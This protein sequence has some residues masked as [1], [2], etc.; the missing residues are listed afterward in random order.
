M[1]QKTSTTTCKSRL[2][3]R[4]FERQ[5]ELVKTKA[6]AIHLK[7]SDSESE[8][9]ISKKAFHQTS[10]LMQIAIQ[11]NKQQ[12]RNPV[13]CL[14]QYSHLTAN[15][16]KQTRQ[17]CGHQFLK[18][19]KACFMI[20]LPIRQ[21]LLQ[22]L[23]ERAILENDD[24]VSAMVPDKE[25]RG[26]IASGGC[27]RALVKDGIITRETMTGT[28]NIDDA[29]FFKSSKFF[30]WPCMA[31]INE[32][33]LYNQSNNVDVCTQ[34]PGQTITM[35]MGH[36]RVYPKPGMFP[37]F[38][39]RSMEQHDADLQVLL[40]TKKPYHGICGTNSLMQF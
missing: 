7:K 37:T 16:E 14:I 31:V 29:E 10:K 34:Y 32:I 12:L 5:G 27:C 4:K 8:D 25:M 26:D 38:P 18:E 9:N 15:I 6:L 19:D 40:E 33:L 30:F 24:I 11:D 13:L 23:Q 3:M 17:P 22:Y 1:K 20:K 2:L 36:S 28:I 39:V 35:K 21:Q